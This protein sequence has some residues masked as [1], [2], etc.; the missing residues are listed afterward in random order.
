MNLED[1]LNE[2]AE[3]SQLS[4]YAKALANNLLATDD[5]SEV[6]KLTLEFAIAVEKE[7]LRLAEKL[8]E[9]LLF[10]LHHSEA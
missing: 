7:R 2:L 10:I 8:T 4:P 6:L 9:A 3:L 1:Q 5:E